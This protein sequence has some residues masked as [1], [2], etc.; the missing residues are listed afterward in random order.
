MRF[1]LTLAAAFFALPV[2]AADIVGIA[3]VI[4]GGP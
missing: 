1:T 3:S 2:L 4:D